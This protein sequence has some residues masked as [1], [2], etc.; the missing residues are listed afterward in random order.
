MSQYKKHLQDLYSNATFRRK[1]EYIDYNFGQ[2]L[3]LAVKSGQ[4]VLEIGPGMGELVGYLNN[5]GCRQIDVVDNDKHILDEI[6]KNFKTRRR[7]L[8]GNIT[9]LD[10]KLTNF[11]TIV[12]IQVLE[13]M[14]VDLLPKV[15]AIL[16]KHL[17]RGGEMVFVVP[18]AGNPL[19][20]VER[21]GDWQHTTA[22]TEQSL[23]DLVTVSGIKNYEVCLSGYQ[24]P[25]SGLINIVRIVVQKILHLFLLGLMIANGGTFFKILSP[26]IV[27]KIK[28]L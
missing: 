6:G 17:D 1:V 24:I 21:Y 28:K 27:L 3:K 13:H 9:V 18:N 20:L 12:G 23:K 7:F 19:G 2:W 14:S 25:P 26:N 22:F 5:L 16:Y 4:S 8:N 11:R 15:I 10:N